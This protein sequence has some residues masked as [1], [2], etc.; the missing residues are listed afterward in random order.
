MN[1]KLLLPIIALSINAAAGEERSRPGPPK[2]NMN[3]DAMSALQSGIPKIPGTENVA[4][5]KQ[6]VDDLMLER[7]ELTDK[8]T[9]LNQDTNYQTNKLLSY[10]EQINKLKEEL[11][12]AKQ[13]ASDS[14]QLMEVL[15]EDVVSYQK[16][17]KFHKDNEASY[18]ANIRSK[19]EEVQDLQQSVQQLSAITNNPGFVFDGWVYSEEFGWVFSNPDTYPYLFVSG[20]DGTSNTWMF[21]EQGSNPRAFFL[22]QTNEWVVL[23][24]DNV[25]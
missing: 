16:V 19:T 7:K 1:I 8:V 25:E 5:L 24:Q 6:M 12:A 20:H 18:I 17:I 2:T 11:K 14:K 15:K 13:D 23:D 3:K 21:Y 4:L 9:K 22:F 10:E